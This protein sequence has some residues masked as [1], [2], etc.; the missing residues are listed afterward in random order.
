MKADNRQYPVRSQQLFAIGQRCFQLVQLAINI[1]TQGLKGAGGTIGLA[2]FRARHDRMDNIGQ[3]AGALNARIQ[4]G[5]DNRS[6]N[7]ARGTLLAKTPDNIGQLCLVQLVDNIAGIAPLPRHP[8]IQ[9][10]IGAKGKAALGLVQ[11][12]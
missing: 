5:T 11:L 4:T 3:L 10:A 6:G 9:R 8:H 1:D 2:G 12:G 7:P